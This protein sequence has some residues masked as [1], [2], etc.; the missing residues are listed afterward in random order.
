M[1][2][3]VSGD[4]Q[5]RL[6]QTATATIASPSH[7]E[8]QH[9]IRLILDGGNQR[10]YVPTH[11]QQALG[12]PVVHKELLIIRPFGDEQ[13][14]TRECD[15]VEID[16]ALQDGSHTTVSAISV[17][18]ISS[19]F[20]GQYIADAMKKYGHLQGMK[21]A[22]NGEGSNNVDMLLGADSYWQIVTG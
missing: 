15:I 7:P 21:L 17:P 20:E 18:Y 1:T 10:S 4:H 3:T 13:G 8:T 12:L 22:D 16:L 5:A 6:L 2:G 19:E 9:Q 14:S 11:T